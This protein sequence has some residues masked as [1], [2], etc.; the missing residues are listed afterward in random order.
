MKDFSRE[1]ELGMNRCSRRSIVLFTKDWKLSRTP[2]DI[3]IR[4]DKIRAPLDYRAGPRASTITPNI[5]PNLQSMSMNFSRLTRPL[6][7]KPLRTLTTS[8][9]ISPRTKDLNSNI[10]KLAVAP[11]ARAMHIQSIPM[12]KSELLSLPLIY[13]LFD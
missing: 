10:I 5:L 8:V 11:V 6:V 9:S 2:R 3:D 12:C 13:A 4:S 1:F 7:S